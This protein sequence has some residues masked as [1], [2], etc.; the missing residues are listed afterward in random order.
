MNN[1]MV[2]DPLLVNSGK[3]RPVNTNKSHSRIGGLFA[4]TAASIC[5][6]IILIILL[7]VPITVLVIGTR[8]RDPRY[9]PIEPRISLFLIVNGAVSIGWIIFTILTTVMA[10]FFAAQRSLISVVLVTILSI[11]LFLH[12]IFSIIWLI[13]GSVWTFS[14]HNR[15]THEYDTINH[16][17][18]F[19]YC[20]PVLYKFTFIYL[21]ISY[22]L[23]A[24][25]CFY[26][27]LTS[28]FRSRQ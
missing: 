17:Y 6:L 12:L 10:I 25:Q 16:F 26:Q 14:V 8:Y 1:K 5:C 7:A 13:I 2:L 27:C 21:I 9:C 11:V 24:I 18:P 4:G 23:I 15:V 28:A 3:H 19:N 20:N 22:V